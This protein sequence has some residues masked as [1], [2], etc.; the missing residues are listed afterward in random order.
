MVSLHSGAPENFNKNADLVS[1]LF[2]FSPLG[3]LSGRSEVGSVPMPLMLPLTTRM[4]FSTTLL[5]KQPNFS[6]QKVPHPL[7]F[8]HFHIEQPFKSLTYS[9]ILDPIKVEMEVITHLLPLLLIFSSFTPIICNA[10]P[11]IT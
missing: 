3:S 2:N 9:Q 1:Y 4:S 6:L 11:P 10:L 8:S 7:T 5:I